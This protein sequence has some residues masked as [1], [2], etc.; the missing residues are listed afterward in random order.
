MPSQGVQKVF[1]VP[2]EKFMFL[3]ENIFD[4]ELEAWQIIIFLRLLA[5]KNDSFKEDLPLL[6]IL[7]NVPFFIAS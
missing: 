5:I 3:I 6:Q 2:T 1:S 7:N 4:E